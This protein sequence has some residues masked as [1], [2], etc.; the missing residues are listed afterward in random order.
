MHKLLVNLLFLTNCSLPDIAYDVGRLSRYT[1]Y[2]SIEHWDAIF[3]L[4]RY[5]KGTL[6]FGLSYCGYPILEGYFD[7]NWVFDTDEVKPTGGYLF[8]L[9]G[10]VVSSKSSK[11][12]YIVRST[13]E[14]EL[15]A[16]E[17]TR[18]KVV[19]FRSLFIDMPLFIN[20]IA[21]ICIHCD[22]KAV[23]ARAKS[24]IYNGKSRHIRLRHKV[25]RQLIDNGIMSLDFVRFVRS[26]ADPL[27]KP[28]ARR[29]I[30]KTSWGIG[31]IPK[32]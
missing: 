5:L 15:G 20:S 10:G 23:I 6:D 13:M 32:L 19:W 7:A 4:L 1:H 27:T 21:S 17:K 22:C 29:L 16:S 11:Q 24:K 12:T 2:P 18:F 30:S 31:L 26:L 14:A 3:I 8:T 25:L 9:V 28:L